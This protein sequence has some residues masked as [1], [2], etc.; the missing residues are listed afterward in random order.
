MEHYTQMIKS[1]KRKTYKSEYNF[2]KKNSVT[3][4]KDKYSSY[5]AIYNSNVVIGVNS[6]MLFEKFHLEVK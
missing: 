6:T 5:K 3:R 4:E 1:F 2:L